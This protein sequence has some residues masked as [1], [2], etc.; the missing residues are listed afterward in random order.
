MSSPLRLVMTDRT[1][2]L[3]PVFSFLGFIIALIPLPWHLQAWNSGTCLFMIWTSLGCLNLFINSI[4]WHGN[5]HNKAPIWCDICE[6]HPHP[7]FVLLLTLLLATRFIVGLAVAIPA[8]L[9]CI[10]RRLYS[11][12]SVRASGI[13]RTDVRY[14]P[15]D[16]NPT[17]TRCLACRG[18]GQLS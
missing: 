10:S 9:L 12:S 1:Y 16:L 7:V 15:N 17:L 2:P 8:S 13:T 4:L 11:I 5:V 18:N 3:Y 6:Q 14:L